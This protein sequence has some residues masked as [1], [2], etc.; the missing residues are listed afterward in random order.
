MK[1]RIAITGAAGTL[2]RRLRVHWWEREDIELVLLD[3][4][5]G[6]DDSIIQADLSQ[7]DEGWVKWLAGVDTIVHLA[8]NANAQADSAALVASNID[9]V[10][11]IYRAAVQ[12]GVARVILASSVW[13]M[14]GRAED[15]LPIL[16][17][18]A[19]PGGNAYGQSKAFA[20]QLAQEVAGK[21]ATLA[22][23]MGGCAPGENAPV[24]K[25]RWENSCWLSSGDFCRGMD[26]ALE[27]DIQ[28]FAVVNLT[29]DIPGGRWDLA[30]T[31]QVMGYVPQDRFAPPAPASLV[32]RGVRKAR[33]V[34]RQALPRAGDVALAADTACALGEGPLWDEARQ[35]VWFLDI[36]GGALHRYDAAH[37]G[38]TQVPGEPGFAVHDRAGGLLLGV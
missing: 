15:D 24:H 34:L 10:R 21:P 38:V 17:E 7:W 16:A 6:G 29:S 28:G 19:Q 1:R 12:Q 4:A 18:A 25:N 11:H 22:L 33:R 35:C 32:R 37:G 36:L 8:A 13:A 30:H 5:P 27:A 2:G 26:C 9:A 14:A 23:R 31:R 20:E 3:L